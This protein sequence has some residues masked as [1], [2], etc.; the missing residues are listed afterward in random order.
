M[1]AE[2]LAQLNQ[3]LGREFDGDA[4]VVVLGGAGAHE[5]KRSVYRCWPQIHA[6]ATSGNLAK[7][8][9]RD[10]FEVRGWCRLNTSGLTPPR[11]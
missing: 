8:T 9:E 3:E 7:E 4:K 2:L 5:D 10:L 11:V 1:E 6:K